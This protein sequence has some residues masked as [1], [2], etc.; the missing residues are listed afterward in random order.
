V[1]VGTRGGEITGCQENGSVYILF[2]LRK[3]EG[4]N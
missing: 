4:T 2:K 1:P 3:L